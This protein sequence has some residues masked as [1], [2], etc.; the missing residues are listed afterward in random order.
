MSGVG[1]DRVYICSGVHQLDFFKIGDQH[2]VF[3]DP[4]DKLIHHFPDLAE[5]NLRGYTSDMNTQE[6]LERVILGI[7][8]DF[9]DFLVYDE[10]RDFYW[11][12][13]PVTRGRQREIITRLVK[14]DLA[15]PRTID[16]TIEYYDVKPV[17]SLVIVIDS[18][19][20]SKKGQPTPELVEGLVMSAG[21]H[22]LKITRLYERGQRGKLQRARYRLPISGSLDDY[23]RE[24][25]V[26]SLLHRV[27]NSYPR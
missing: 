2:S 4:V 1:E 23:L 11:Q 25:V 27:A 12:W 19:D 20:L 10:M 13:D 8:K 21:D 26:D 9:I 14:R 7:R 3:L 16:R 22:K 17:G 6:K 24:D 18:S 15:I 5:A